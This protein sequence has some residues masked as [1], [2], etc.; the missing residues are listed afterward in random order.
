MNELLTSEPLRSICTS[1]GAPGVLIWMTLVASIE[2]NLK[3]I[4]AFVDGVLPHLPP[5]IWPEGDEKPENH[6]RNG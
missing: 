4:S 6:M 2:R 5:D 3:H 1:F